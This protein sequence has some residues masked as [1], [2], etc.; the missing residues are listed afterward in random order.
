MDKDKFLVSLFAGV[1]SVFYAEVLSGSSILW[2]LDPFG[3]IV[4]LPL[5]MFHLLLL[6]N[7]AERFNRLSPTSLYLFGVI[8][9]LYETWMTKVVWAG[10]INGKPILGTPLGFAVAEMSIVTFFWHPIMSFIFPLVTIK[11]L[12]MNLG[13]EDSVSSLWAPKFLVKRRLNLFYF[14]FLIVFSA[15]AVAFNSGFNLI[16][17][18]VGIL[19]T[20]GMVFLIYKLMIRRNSQAV[21]L[22]N[23]IL[24]NRAII[25][26][27]IYLLALYVIFFIFVRT[28]AIPGL[29]TI[30]LTVAFY[31]FIAF[32]IYIDR[33]ENCERGIAQVED[34][35]ILFEKRDLERFYLL[36]IILNISFVAIGAAVF[37][38]IG[39]LFLIIFVTGF[40]LLFRAIIMA[41]KSC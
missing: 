32:L 16:V 36:T 23:L 7:L 18:L 25:L 40:A 11:V 15:A 4:L 3:F 27:S 2:F 24:S 13:N 34:D 17:S 5:Y 6:F 14:Y 30:L 12:S 35:G 41:T 39:L 8:F 20:L 33:G 9:G 10:F 37:P 26:I 1:L 29:L 28:E 21:T 31:G 38:L 19:G 22:D